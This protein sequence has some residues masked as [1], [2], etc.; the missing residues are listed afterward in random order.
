[1]MIAGGLVTQK[2]INGDNINQEQAEIERQ[3]AIQRDL[4][5]KQLES[6]QMKPVDPNLEKKW[7][8]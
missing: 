6:Q 7:T 5:R 4:M 8:V 2:P 1:M 3:A